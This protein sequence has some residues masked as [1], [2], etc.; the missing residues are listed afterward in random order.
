MCVVMFW[1][2]KQIY[3]VFGIS[4]LKGHT[5]RAFLRSVKPCSFSDPGDSQPMVSQNT[6]QT[7]TALS[8]LMT[9]VISDS[10]DATLT[11]SV[12]D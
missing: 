7:L 10:N 4:S 5:E 1:N 11:F 6:G 12:F 3:T 2:W 8:F 9:S